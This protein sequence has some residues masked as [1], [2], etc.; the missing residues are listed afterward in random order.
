MTTEQAIQITSIPIEYSQTKQKNI[1]LENIIKMLIERGVIKPAN[2]TSYADDVIKSV[3]D[4]DTCDIQIV[5]GEP[6][7]SE[8]YKIILLLDQ[9]ISTITKTSIIGEY[10]YKSPKEHKIIIVQDITQRA[11]LSI[12]QS[13]P[14]V[15][16]FLK[17]E[18]MFNL[19]ES[20][21]VPKHILLSN[22]DASRFI[23]EYGVQKK[24]LPRIFISDPVARYY[25]AKIGQIFQIIRPSETS[26]FS[27]YYR[28]VVNDSVA[29]K[30]K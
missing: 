8:I 4:N 1:V 14:L 5:H 11:R 28:I 22:D 29:R 26:G 13:F 19:I 23:S 2:Y 17:R 12:Q 21:Y 24:E 27:N 3:K 25:H 7:D 30:S 6:D 15:E 20:I 9:K 16:V 18:L 10:I